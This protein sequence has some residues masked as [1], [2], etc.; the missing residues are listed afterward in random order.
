[1]NQKILTRSGMNIN[2]KQHDP[3]Y[4]IISQ[5]FDDTDTDEI[6]LN[7]SEIPALIEK[8]QEYYDQTQLTI[9]WITSFVEN[10]NPTIVIKE[11]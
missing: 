9:L 4:T 11:K 8:L 10:T 1:M 2:I 5:E 7:T 6:I 3:T